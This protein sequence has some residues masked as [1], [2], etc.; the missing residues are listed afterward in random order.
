[1]RLEAWVSAF[2][3]FSV[4]IIGGVMFITDVNTNYNKNVST[5]DFGEVYNTSTEI[6]DIGEGMK[7]DTFG[8]DVSDETSFESMI[9]GSYSA[10]R[11]VG[12]TFGLFR[13]IADSIAN[14]IGIPLFFV[15]AAITAV[16][17]A[18]V[19]ALIQIIRGFRI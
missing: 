9:K 4:F 5:S 14:K 12:G 3:V 17:L 13:S 10:L 16:I 2:I 15:I 11:L 8:A 1:M 18:I 6:Y 19:F 7:N